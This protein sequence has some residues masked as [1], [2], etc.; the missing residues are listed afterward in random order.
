MI[1]KNGTA[2]IM[3]QDDTFY[4]SLGDYVEIALP[5]RE[6]DREK[7]DAG[8]D[9]LTAGWQDD[10]GISATRLLADAEHTYLLEMLEDVRHCALNADCLNRLQTAGFLPDSDD[11]LDDVEELDF[12]LQN[13]LK[14]HWLTHIAQADG[15]R[16]WVAYSDGDWYQ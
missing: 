10:Q 12:I 2:T 6:G 14:D 11:P 3:E 15:T 8:E 7:L 9:P 4:V 5:I 13:S 1:W 16:K